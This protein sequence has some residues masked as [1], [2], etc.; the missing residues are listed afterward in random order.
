MGYNMSNHRKINSLTALHKLTDSQ[1]MVRGGVKNIF[2][3]N[4]K[5][6]YTIKILQSF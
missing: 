5:T 6:Y 2:H 1:T 4:V 3:I